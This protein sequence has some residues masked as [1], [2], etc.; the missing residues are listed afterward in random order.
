MSRITFVART[1][2]VA[3]MVYHKLPCE[4][5]LPLGGSRG[6]AAASI[7]VPTGV[8]ISVRR[9]GT[10]FTGPFLPFNWD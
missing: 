5:R 6:K 8:P 1:S 10:R 2:L 7:T 4:I 9:A 3:Q